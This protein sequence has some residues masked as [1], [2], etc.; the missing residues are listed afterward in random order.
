MLSSGRGAASALRAKHAFRA[1]AGAIKDMLYFT[2]FDGN[3]RQISFFMDHNNMHNKCILKSEV[4]LIGFN[5]GDFSVQPSHQGACMRVANE[6]RIRNDAGH[7]MILQQIASGISYLDFGNTHLPRDFQ[8]Y[9]VKYSDRTAEP[10]EDGSFKIR[11]TGEIYKP[12]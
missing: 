12:L 5:E 3:Q 8:G 10:Q 6:I 1:Q 2:N 9:R 7:E 11:N 4:K